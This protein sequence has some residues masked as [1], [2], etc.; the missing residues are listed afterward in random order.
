MLEDAPNVVTEDGLRDLLQRGWRAEVICRKS[1]E[2]RANTWAG[3]WVVRALGPDGPG[4]RDEKL[5]V[6]TRTVLRMREFK[7]V[8][9]V[10]SFLYDI[11][12]RVAQIPLEAGGRA[13]HAL[14]DAA[15]EAPSAD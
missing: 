2:K 9:G 8:V 3:V 1:G 13:A 15:P 6:N 14:P 11:G 7:T 4:G 12:L 10:I 5:L